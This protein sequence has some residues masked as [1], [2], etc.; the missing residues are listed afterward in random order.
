MTAT[1][2]N[3]GGGNQRLILTPTNPVTKP[4]I[5][6][7]SVEGIS[8]TTFKFCHDQPGWSGAT[9]TDLTNWMRL[10]HRRHPT[11]VVHQQHQRRS[12]TAC[13]SNSSGGSAMATTRDDTAIEE[14]AKAF[15]DAY[16]EV[17]TT[18]DTLK[19]GDLSGD[20]TLRSIVSGMRNTLNI[21]PT[22]LMAPTAPC[23][24]SASR[25]TAIP[26]T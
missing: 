8:D 3:V 21:Q 14:S 15:V 9:I 11:H 10:Q 19:A 20:S 25:P 1:I 12:S 6:C 4:R 26:A 22:G 13:R 18:I 16:N 23:R 7:R 5:S 24:R 17:L 2:L